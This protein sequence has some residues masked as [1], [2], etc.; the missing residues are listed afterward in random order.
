MDSIFQNIDD[1]KMQIKNSKIGVFYNTKL[2]K[3]FRILSS[4]LSWTVFVLLLLCA[5]FLIYYYIASQVYA[6][7]GAG[8]EPQISLFT[9]ISPSMVPNI[10]VYDVVVVG[11]EKNPA[12]IKVGDIISFN[13]SDFIIGETISVTHRVVEVLIDEN[14][15]YS[16]YTKG[17]F[18]EV[19]D[20]K[21][22]PYESITGEVMFRLPQLG[23]VQFFLASSLGWMLVVVL[24]ALYVIIKMI[25]KA[26]KINR[27][28]LK[29]PNTS[30]FYSLFNKQLLLTYKHKNYYV[31]LDEEEYKVKT[32]YE[33][34]L[35]SLEKIYEDLKEMSK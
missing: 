31:N 19:R 5:A 24:P 26:L 35:P 17:D 1:I 16:Y 15:N 18:N 27:L 3:P 33:D 12:E 2:K 14:G 25:F 21:P 30:K 34:G 29:I 11:K 6:R 13:S 10:D 9:I 23:R 22:V 32:Y 4:I 20:P 28:G 7:K 8:Y